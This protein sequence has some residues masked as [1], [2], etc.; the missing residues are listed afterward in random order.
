MSFFFYSFSFLECDNGTVYT[1]RLDALNALVH[2]FLRRHEVGLRRWN[3]HILQLDTQST[4]E[5][6]FCQHDGGL[7]SNYIIS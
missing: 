3:T 6:F 1:G 7:V 5:V 2:V 4:E